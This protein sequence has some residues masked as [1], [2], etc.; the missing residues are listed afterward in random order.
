MPY[1]ARAAIQISDDTGWQ[2][3]FDK[4]VQRIVPLYGAFAELLLALGLDRNIVARTVADANIA[5]LRHLPAVGTHMRPNA[6]LIVAH[7]PDVVLQLVGRHEA[8]T[9]GQDLRRLGVPVLLFRIESFED[10]FAVL[11]QLGA[12]TGTSERAQA[13]ERQYRDRLEAVR[14]RIGTAAPVS[15]FY[16]V[17]YPNL[18]AAGKDSIVNDIIHRAGG[19]NVVRTEGKLVRLN[20]EELIRLNPAAYILQ[21]GPMNPSPVPVERRRH[22]DPLRAAQSGRILMVDELTFARPG[23]RAVDAVETLAQWLH[24]TAWK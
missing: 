3:H 9:L 13:L 2:T 22:Y 6:E 23:P 19:V 4:P 18:L 20:E 5:D 17:R 12:M 24:P 8:T 16:E 1:A 10:M 14:Q 11:R 7:K 15:V 21:H